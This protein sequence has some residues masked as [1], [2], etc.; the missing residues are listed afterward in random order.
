MKKHLHKALFASVLLVNAVAASAAD[1]LPPEV[2]ATIDDTTIPAEEF[3]AAVHSGARNKFYHGNIP[4]GEM[5]RFQ[6]EVGQQMIE[7]AL[8]LDEARR[9]GVDA[10]PEWVQP[11]LDAFERRASR[12]P[13][14]EEQGE[15][16][17]RAV[18]ERLGNESRVNNLRA[19]VLEGVGTPSDSVLRAYYE[20]NPEKFTEPERVRVSTILLEV[21]PSAA[22][23]VWTAAEEEA[24]GIVAKLR[25]GADFA[26]TARLRSGDASATN[27][28]D[29][30]YLHRG[31]LG[32]RA[33]AAIDA[34]EIG[35]ITD[36]V[37]LLEGV[38]IFRV[39]ERPVARLR[40]F[41]EVA[42]R[43]RDLWLRERRESLWNEFRQSLRESAEIRINEQHYL[44]LPG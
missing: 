42:E 10:D 2:F 22:S 5:A 41:D 34:A 26:E 24:T 1:E 30:G 32:Q 39:D 25:A 14:W 13:A 35:K 12:H 3:K 17:M 27:G 6:R 15:E 43:A 20:A 9:R 7:N 33:Q 21:E 8:L 29:M 16:A 40:P 4:A 11:R 38:A 44:P 23:A 37:R 19:M 18:E 28:G 31:M 36:P